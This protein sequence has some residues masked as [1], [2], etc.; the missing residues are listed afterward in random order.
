MDDFNEKFNELEKETKFKIIQLEDEVKDDET[1]KKM[2][3]DFKNNLVTMI[4]KARI[5]AAE[6]KDSEKV[7]KIYQQ[8]KDTT[9]VAID[10]AI[11]TF[12]EL[13]DNEKVQDV[14]KN[15]NIGFNKVVDT[16]SENETVKNVTETIGDKF[17]EIKS[18]EKVQEGFK[19]AKES[20]L[21]VA[22]KL[23]KGLSDFISDKEKE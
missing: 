1:R 23:Q 20:T 10:K 5:K 19:T 2:L 9:S 14:L 17:E 12:N 6:A 8:A 4:E 7:Q 15:I 21:K 3:N 18:N 13:K 22:G 11:E 16:I